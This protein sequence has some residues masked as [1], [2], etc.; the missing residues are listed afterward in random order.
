[1]I[2][3]FI[4]YDRYEHDEWFSLYYIGTDRDAAE[5]E[6]IEQHLPGFIAYGPDDCHSFQLVSVLLP[7]KILKKLCHFMA[8]SENLSREEQK[9]FDKIMMEIHHCEKYEVDVIYSTD[10]QSD[11]FEIINHY[12]GSE[13]NFDD[14]D[15]E[16]EYDEAYEEYEAKKEKLLSDDELFEKITK[17]Y[18]LRNY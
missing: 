15:T 1:M 5:Q 16:E 11:F 14:F 12:C 2:E 13:P 4:T 18:I 10:G 8:E 6:F 3:T 17:E 7:Q 9:E